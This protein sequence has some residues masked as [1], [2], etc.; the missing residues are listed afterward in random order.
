MKRDS[1]R[2]FRRCAR[3]TLGF[4]RRNNHH[5]DRK[6]SLLIFQPF[7]SKQFQAQR[8]PGVN[9]GI[10]NIRVRGVRP[11]ETLAGRAGRV[12]TTIRTV[13]SPLDRLALTEGRSRT[14]V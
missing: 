4:D 5:T 7:S 13:T 11:G 3:M 12:N 14:G 1:P 9:Y 2:F 6:P 10:D 8:R